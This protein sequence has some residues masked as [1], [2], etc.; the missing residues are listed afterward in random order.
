MGDS[1]TLDG[2][3]TAVGVAVNEVGV[4]KGV[5]L[6]EGEAAGDGRVG[7]RQLKVQGYA[8]PTCSEE[9]NS[10]ALTIESTGDGAGV[11]LS[12][13]CT[14]GARVSPGPAACPDRTASR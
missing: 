13:T 4:G 9:N 2:T 3:P 12:V 14:V 10:G 6:A 1:E 8:R 5:G 11:G 7:W